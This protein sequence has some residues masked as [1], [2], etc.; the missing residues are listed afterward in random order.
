MERE[1]RKVSGRPIAVNMQLRSGKVGVQTLVATQNV[2]HGRSWGML[3]S[4]A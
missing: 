1:E 3:V 4:A 2:A